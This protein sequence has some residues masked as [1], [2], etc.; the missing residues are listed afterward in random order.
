M[1]PAGA[2]AAADGADAAAAAAAAAGG[3]ARNRRALAYPVLS[4][5]LTPEQMQQ[6]LLMQQQQMGGIMALGGMPQPMVS[7][8]LEPVT[9]QPTPNGMLAL[10]PCRWT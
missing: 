3:P 1:K 8:Q 5:Q 10:L 9:A 2:G 6:A 4:P 7:A